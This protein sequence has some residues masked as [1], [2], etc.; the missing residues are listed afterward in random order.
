MYDKEE[1]IL[2]QSAIGKTGAGALNQRD[3]DAKIQRVLIASR[4]QVAVR[5]AIGG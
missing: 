5:I 1:Q 2:E 3:A 4:T